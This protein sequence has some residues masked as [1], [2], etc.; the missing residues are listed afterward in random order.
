[1]QAPA[2][3]S[4]RGPLPPWLPVLGGGLPWIRA[5]TSPGGL[6]RWHQVHGGTL[7][8]PRVLEPAPEPEL[9]RDVGAALVGMAARAKA[10]SPDRRGASRPRWLTR[11]RCR[12][13][14]REEAASL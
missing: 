6:L 10:A 4:R 13:P 3:G 7:A 9:H 2:L 12:H 1:M 5:A 14:A 8:Q 11:R